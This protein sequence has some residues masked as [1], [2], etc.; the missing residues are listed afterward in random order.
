[1]SNTRILEQAQ[2][3]L[4][5]LRHCQVLGLQVHDASPLGLTLRLPY[6]RQIACDPEFGVMHRG[7][8]T[9]MIASAI[10]C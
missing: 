5:A 6:N 7:A 3:F 4:A 9:T 2:R 10:G 1:M 8:I